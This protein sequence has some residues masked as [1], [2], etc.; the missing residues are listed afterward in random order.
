MVA[1]PHC[2]TPNPESLTSCTSCGGALWATQPTPSPVERDEVPIPFLTA[3]D[4]LELEPEPAPKRPQKSKLPVLE[5]AVA[6][7]LLLGAGA[8]VWM[9]HSSLPAKTAASA[10]N[11][12]VTLTP[13]SAE[14]GAGKGVDFSASVTGTDNV[15]V[16]WSLQEGD[17]GGRIVTRGAKAE[18]GQVSS[19]VQYVA[20]DTP[21]TYHLVATSKADPQQS[22]QAEITVTKAARKKSR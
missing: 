4:R 8:A 2:G 11:V 7:L 21:G 10:A 17:S 15:E 16:D 18:A 9:L 5:I 1:C 22:A 13:A 14:V 20:P 19:L 3:Y 6:V 12:A